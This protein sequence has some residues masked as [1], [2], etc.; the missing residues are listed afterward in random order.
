MPQRQQR[1]FTLVE[2]MI[3]VAIVAILAMIS[4]PSY[5]DYVL[6]GKLNEA[7]SQLASLQMRMEQYY[8]DNRMYNNSG[9][10]GACGIPNVNGTQFNFSCTPSNCSGTPETC[11]G[12]TFTATG[13]N[14][15]TGFAYTIN[16]VGTRATTSTAANWGPNNAGCWVRGKGGSC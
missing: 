7:F 12:F 5:T 14:A 13:I 15:A 9:A 2:L 8:Q 11:Q 6:R 1:A 3:V 10:S 16:E 4:Y